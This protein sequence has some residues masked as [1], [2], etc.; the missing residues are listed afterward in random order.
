MLAVLLLLAS[1]SSRSDAT[2]PPPDLCTG[3]NADL[4]TLLRQ[5]SQRMEAQQIPYSSAAMADCSGIFLR[6]LDSLKQFCP[7]Q[8]YPNPARYRSSRDLAKWYHEQG[9]LQLI[10]NPL[11]H[12]DQLRAGMVLFYGQRKSLGG[13]QSLENLIGAGGINHLGLVLGVQKDEQG[14]IINYA[15]FHGLRPGKP[16]AITRFH[17]RKPSQQKYPPFGNGTEPWVAAAPIF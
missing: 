8:A 7:N 16:A 6:V 15:L 13:K 1:C 12:T 4:I 5:V 9:R 14:E 2:E 11:E 3:V 17:Y 10:A